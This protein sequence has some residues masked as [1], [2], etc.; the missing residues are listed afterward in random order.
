MFILNLIKIYHMKPW[1]HKIE[2]MV[3]RIIPYLLILLLFIIIGEVFYAEKL[4]SYHFFVSAFDGFIVFIFALDLMF[5]YIH[6][7]NFPKFFRKYWLE[8]IAIFPAF[9]V[10]RLFEEF[11][12][13]ANVDKTQAYLHEAVEIKREG[14]LIIMEAEKIGE[15]SRIRLFEQFIRPIARMPRFLK[16]FRFYRRILRAFR[17]YEKPT[18]KHHPNEKKAKL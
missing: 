1:L 2:V 8:I 5:K 4:E 3:D 15:A 14:R 12:P 10:L 13:L 16:A 6:I 11:I 7:R 9:L 17:F 18:R